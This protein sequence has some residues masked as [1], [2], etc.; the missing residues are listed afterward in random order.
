[1]LERVGNETLHEQL[2]SMAQPIRE[3][4]PHPHAN[5]GAAVN[6]AAPLIVE[7]HPMFPGWLA[8]FEHLI[9]A[10]QRSKAGVV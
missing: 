9:K 10:H 8:A 3:P 1:M 2:A 4:V 6:P 7:E 5:D